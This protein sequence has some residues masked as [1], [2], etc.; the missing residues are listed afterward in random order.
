MSGSNQKKNIIAEGP[1]IIL[2]EPQL[3]ENIGMVARAM[4]N[5]GLGELRIVA[6][7]DGWPN[8]R[9][10]VA[11][12][13]ANHIIED[14]KVYDTVEEAIGDLRYV[15]ATTARQRDMITTVHGPKKAAQLMRGWFDEGIPTGLLFGRER[16]GLNNSEVALCDAIVT[17]PVNPGFASLNI[18]QAVLL[19]SYEWMT[20]RDDHLAT[21][22][23][24]GSDLPPAAREEL[25]GLVD[26]F[27]EALEEVE[28]FYPPQRRERMRLNLQSIFTH[29][30]LSEP[31]IRT[32]RGVVSA[33]QRRWAKGQ[34]KAVAEND[35][36]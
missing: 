35:D 7:R 4:A 21:Q 3:G 33:L 17:F 28:Y 15:F 36:A 22:S 5:F 31:E 12:S 18:A 6:P 26:H 23:F 8:E 34:A 19:M 13:G 30:Q 25:I 32:L 10:N 16:W 24:T 27:E 11:A 2:A 29:A 9:A 1:A 14:A 20:T